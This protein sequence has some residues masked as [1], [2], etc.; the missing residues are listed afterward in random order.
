M[1]DWEI[2]MIGP[3]TGTLQSLR[4]DAPRINPIE[5]VKTPPASQNAPTPA[6]TVTL[7]QSD[8]QST[9]V[10]NRAGIVG[11][12]AVPST[13]AQASPT[14]AASTQFDVQQKKQVEHYSFIQQAAAT[15]PNDKTG[16]R[17]SILT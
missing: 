1:N 2:T 4:V 17:L 5:P 11:K 10:Y 3:I 8:E 13:P 9:G 7:G 16:A 6:A 14:S 15:N 12:S